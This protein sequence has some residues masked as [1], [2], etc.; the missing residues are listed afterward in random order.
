MWSDG[1]L[2]AG[3]FEMKSLGMLSRFIRCCQPFCI[4][5]SPKLNDFTV[6][7]LLKL[8]C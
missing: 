8:A 6:M 7:M 5:F 1:P 2:R 3:G 4:A